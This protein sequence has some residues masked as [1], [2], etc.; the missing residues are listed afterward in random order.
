MPTLTPF[1]YA[2]HRRNLIEFT[3][4]DEVRVPDIGEWIESG[5]D[6]FLNNKLCAE[7]LVTRGR[8]PY[9]ILKW[10]Y[11]DWRDNTIPLT[12][13]EAGYFDALES[14]PKNKGVFNPQ[15]VLAPV[16][17][18]EVAEYERG[19]EDGLGERQVTDVFHDLDNGDSG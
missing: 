19:Y 2:I 3:P 4:T 16:G 6:Q 7:T 9:K 18:D 8:N 15:H 5:I 13:Y 17:P 1:F 10:K 14:L 11:E 12:F